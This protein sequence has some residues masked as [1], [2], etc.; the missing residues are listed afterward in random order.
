MNPQSMQTH[1]KAL[2]LGQKQLTEVSNNLEKAL[3][4]FTSWL[5]RTC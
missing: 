4:E 3:S 2:E 1:F 5:P